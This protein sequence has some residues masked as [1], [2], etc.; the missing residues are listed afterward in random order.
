[1]ANV[2]VVDDSRTMRLIMRKLL[3][4]L[5]HKVIA[6]AG[7]GEEAVKAYDTHSPDLVTMDITM[8]VMDGVTAVQEIV[9]RH[10][11]AKIVMV[12]AYGHTKMV[13]KAISMGAKH[14]LVK[15]IIIERARKIISQV[16]SSSAS[17]DAQADLDVLHSASFAIE[18]QESG[19]VVRVQGQ[20]NISE[21]N[22]LQRALEDLIGMDNLR[23]VLLFP[24][25]VSYSLNIIARINATINKLERSGAKVAV[26]TGD[27][28]FKAR[29][30]L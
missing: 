23:I 18:E 10:P 28:D 1:M 4:E 16:L 7:T 30:K 12:S 6:E 13:M 24:D 22:R 17:P 5:G 26:N 29:L 15:P 21:A 20:L 9:A 14:F 8:P 27:K 2:L 25:K 3:D 11:D 19:F